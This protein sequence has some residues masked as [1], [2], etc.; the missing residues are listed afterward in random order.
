MYDA[1]FTSYVSYQVLW[2]VI[3]FV[4]G[5]RIYIGGG[6]VRCPPRG[7]RVNV[8][9]VFD[10]VYRRRPVIVC[11]YYINGCYIY[12]YAYTSCLYTL[13][14]I[15]ICKYSAR[16]TSRTNLPY[17]DR[18]LR[19]REYVWRIRCFRS[20]SVARNECIIIMYATLTT[21]TLPWHNVMR[22]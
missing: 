17:G 12:R 20:D 15:I 7:S 18:S 16:V 9:T 1:Y 5:A 2:N 22:I 14:I 8:A 3:T 10:S 21:T 11:A 19:A 13:D 6:V 4:R